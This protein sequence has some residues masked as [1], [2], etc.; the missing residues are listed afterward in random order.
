MI[1]IADSEIAHKTAQHGTEEK[2][3]A[4]NNGTQLCCTT[5]EKHALKQ[6]AS[7]YSRKSKYVHKL[8]YAKFI[9]INTWKL[10]I[11]RDNNTRNY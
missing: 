3:C 6:Q 8:Y 7:K 9:E 1:P 11:S 2:K 4:N 5:T 10:P